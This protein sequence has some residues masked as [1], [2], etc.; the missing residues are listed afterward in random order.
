MDNLNS[1]YKFRA[2]NGT[3]IVFHATLE[4]IAKSVAVGNYDWGTLN[5]MQYTGLKDKNGREIY[6]FDRL[7]NKWQIEFL[8]G[9]YVLKDISTGD[10]LVCNKANTTDKQISGNLFVQE[11]T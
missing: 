7:D 1:R 9:S 5:I 4:T 2:W 11:N 6:E 8:D 3:S 10:I